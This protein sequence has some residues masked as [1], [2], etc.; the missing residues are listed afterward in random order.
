VISVIRMQVNLTEQ[1][2]KAL[3][4]LAA[5]TGQKRSELIR[6]A[7]R[8][9]LGQ[10]SP[11]RR[12]IVLARAAGIWKKRHDLSGARGMRREWDRKRRP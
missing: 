7:V 12:D 6:E 2:C 4:D 10:S 8:R 3:A 5:A 9:M 11:N 1:Q